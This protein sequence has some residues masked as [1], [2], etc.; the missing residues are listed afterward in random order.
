MTLPLFPELPEITEL[1]ENPTA[2][3]YATAARYALGRGR[4]PLAVQQVAA[5]M[6]LEP[7]ERSHRQL[8]SEVVS[9]TPDPLKLLELSERGTFYGVAAA[10]AWYLASKGRATTAIRLM[11]EVAVF[12]PN[13]PLLIWMEE[14]AARP[15]FARKTEPS[16]VAE[17]VGAF[18]DALKRTEPRE[19]AFRNLSAAAS[20][21]AA[22]S[23]A[24]AD[25]AGLRAARC[26]LLRELGD[27]EGALALALAGTESWATTV[28]AAESCGEL[29][30]RE[31]QR[32]LLRRAIALAPD[33]SSAH[34][35][36]GCALV[37]DEQLAEAEEVFLA[38]PSSDVDTDFSAPAAAAYLRFLRTGDRRLLAEHQQDPRPFVQGLIRE[39]QFFETVL[40]DPLDRVVD[41]IRAAVERGA[42]ELTAGV[43][44]K[45]RIDGC[46][47]PSAHLAFGL[48]LASIGQQGHLTLLGER[49]PRHLGGLW[50]MRDTDPVALVEP[51]NGATAD[52][53]RD[54]A[55]QP[56]DWTNWTR[57]AAQMADY[58][59]DHLL[60][61]A[62]HPPAVPPFIEPVTWLARIH[63][64]VGLL[65]AHNAAPWPERS[66][67][68]ERALAAT[69]DWISNVGIIAWFATGQRDPR[70]IDI[71]PKGFADLFELCGSSPAPSYARTLAVLGSRLSDVSA[72][73]CR[74]LRARLALS[75]RE[76]PFQR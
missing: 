58:D 23:S 9:R 17:L 53:V 44:V 40:P 70:L 2:K 3:D 24:R 63:A 67:A 11:R 19:G 57:A 25:H 72:N 13:V 64:A 47:A 28:E 27:A 41:V 38:A 39:A 34:W 60:R 42:R 10:R 61:V 59:L 32:Q 49:E 55:Q 50:E 12:R 20:F 26:R 62:V 15:D 16:E 21:A 66:S 56:F 30:R 54:L 71:Q 65:I 43:N 14:W 76:F 51:A 74:A 46:A 45:V 4:L 8:L 48:G 73:R 29:G 36:L 37:D 18:L 35:Q 1:V 52:A 75:A 22:V 68:I 6:V 33:G 5:A 31:Q 69:D 7:G